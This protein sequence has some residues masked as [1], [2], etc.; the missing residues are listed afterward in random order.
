MAIG[1]VVVLT[2]IIFGIWSY[3]IK[4]LENEKDLIII[5]YGYD[6]RF[7][8]PKDTTIDKFFESIDRD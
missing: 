6:S 4:G 2:S 1:I 3:N 7:S 8:C 5:D